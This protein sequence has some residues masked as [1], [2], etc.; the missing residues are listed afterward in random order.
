MV[1]TR[2]QQPPFYGH[3]NYTGQP[4]LAGT[5]NSELEDF[6]GAKF[7]CPHA[8]LAATSAF[9]LRIIRHSSQQCYLHG[10]RAG[11]FCRRTNLRL[12]YYTNTTHV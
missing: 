3:Y 12:L 6:V 4:A 11:A 1:T 7:Y 8:L 9:G 2:Q 5:P 10:L